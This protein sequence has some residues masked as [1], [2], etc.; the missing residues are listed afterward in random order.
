MFFVQNATCLFLRFAELVE[1]PDSFAYDV[2]FGVYLYNNYLVVNA[3][4]VVAFAVLLLFPV[5]AVVAGA[6]L[7]RMNRKEETA[8]KT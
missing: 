3:I 2:D 4:S 8:Y 6:L 7:E 5:V 1:N